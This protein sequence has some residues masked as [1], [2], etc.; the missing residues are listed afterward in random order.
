MRIKTF[1]FFSKGVLL[2]TYFETFKLFDR[3]RC[4]LRS[5]RKENHFP[6]QLQLATDDDFMTASGELV[7]PSVGVSD[8]ESGIDISE[9][10]HKSDQNLSPIFGHQ[11]TYIGFWGWRHGPW[12]LRFESSSLGSECSIIR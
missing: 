8:S 10:T 11:F 9:L 12:Y 2:V 3:I 6:V 7:D 1:F 4:Q 5:T